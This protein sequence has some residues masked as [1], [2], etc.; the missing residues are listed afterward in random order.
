MGGGNRYLHLRIRRIVA[1]SES[2]S[3][4]QRFP[5]TC[6]AIHNLQDVVDGEAAPQAAR[7]RAQR[8]TSSLKR[9]SFPATGGV[10]GEGCPK[11]KSSPATGGVNGEGCPNAACRLWRWRQKAKI[12]QLTSQLKAHTFSKSIR[13]RLSEEWILHVMLTSPNVSGRP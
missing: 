10:N 2:A 8:L 11:R 7:E 13:G 1:W 3:N 6:E 9:K 5:R 12:L 4:R